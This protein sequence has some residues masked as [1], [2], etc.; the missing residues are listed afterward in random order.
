MNMEP[1]RVG[2]WERFETSVVNDRVYVDPYADVTLQVTYHR[3]DGSVVRFWG[4]YDGDDTWKA[5][6]M[7]DQLG[8]WRYEAVFSDGAPGTQGEFACVASDLPGLL[9]VEQGNPMWFGYR[10][11]QHVLLRSFHVGDRFFARNWPQARRTAFL[12]WAQAQGYNL[13]SVASHYLNRAQPGRGEG[14]Q[15]PSLWPLDAAEYAKVE[16]L[17]DELDARRMMVFP[18]AGFFGRASNYPTGADEQ[19][20]YIRYVLARLGPYWNLLFNV[21]GPEPLLETE[22]HDPLISKA[23]L[24][25]LG[26]LISALDPFGHLLTVHNRTGDDAFKEEPWSSFGTLQ[27]PKTTDVTELSQGLLRNHHPH[28]PLYAQETLWSGN[29]FHPDYTDVQLR[30][31]AYVVVMS[32]AAFNFADNGG[33]KPGQVGTS[34][35]G[36]SGT[37]ALGDRRQSRHDILKQVWDF[38]ETVPFYG[39]RPRQ[40]LVS[41]GYCLAKEGKHYLVY[42]DAGGAVDVAVRDG[43]YAVQWINAQDTSDRRSGGQ[44]SD[45]QRLSAP[46]DGDD[47]L[48]YLLLPP[49]E[50]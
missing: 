44:T 38:F 12:D 34:S 33:P 21:S 45:G 50:L 22:K 37:L 48:L 35:S 2:Q 24:T 8:V 9:S 27:G 20:R 28:K 40:D 26:R 42:L 6:F 25:R 32:A 13:L 30:K 36:F 29:Q 46:S 19:E 1:K 5:R 17:L 4:F 39:L 15:T 10:D 11:G 49:E 31:N 7:P 16:R 14:W 18:F 43:P 47:W 3:P 41:A 23:D